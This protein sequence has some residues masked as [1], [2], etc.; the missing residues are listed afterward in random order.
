[1]GLRKQV[2][3]LQRL[4]A[5]CVDT[6]QGAHISDADRTGDSRS[7]LGK[8]VSPQE[9]RQYIAEH[10]VDKGE[11]EPANFEE[12]AI[13][14]IGRELYEAFIKGYTRKQW[15]I[16]P[17]QLPAEVIRR[18]PVRYTYNTRY[19]NDTWEGIPSDGYGDWLHRMLSAPGIEVFKKTDFF[20]LRRLI[21][22]SAL[23]VYTGPLDQYFGFRF[24]KL[25]W[26]SLDLETEILDESDFQG[27][28]VMN[29]ADVDVPF[30]RIHEFKHFQPEKFAKTEQT[31]IMKEFSRMATESHDPYYPVNT[32]RDRAMLLEYREAARSDERVIIGGR[33]GSYQY[34]DMH[35]AIASALSVFENEVVTKLRVRT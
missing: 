13:R 3:F 6:T 12:Q 30:T 29:Y 14:L 1:M 2:Y 28:S 34:L 21:P 33:L 5:S 7:F 23:L 20:D 26:R 17:R 4:P 9:A 24:G 27:T 10:Q 19:F 8:A 15:E 16:D 11:S 35:M 22:P 25:L 18:L 32:T 31:V